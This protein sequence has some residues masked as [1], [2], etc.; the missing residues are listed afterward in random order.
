MNFIVTLIPKAETLL[1][2]ADNEK[3]AEA[4]AMDDYLL[5]FENIV[6]T[7]IN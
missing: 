5:E 7:P 6:I 3:E 4:K 1:I 2:Q